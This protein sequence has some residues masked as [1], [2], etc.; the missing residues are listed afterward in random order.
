ME[1]LVL[2]SDAIERILK[3]DE[4]YQLIEIGSHSALEMPIKQIKARLNDQSPHSSALIRFKDG[5]DSIL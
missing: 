5:V 4:K 3:F 1:S 2:F